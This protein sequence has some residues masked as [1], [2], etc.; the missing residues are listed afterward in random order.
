M[1][2]RPHLR[3]G[4][5]T[6]PGDRPDAPGPLASRRPELAR[7]NVPRHAQV[8]T[9]QQEEARIVV[10]PELGDLSD[11][12]LAKAGLPLA[13]AE[14]RIIRGENRTRA[15]CLPLRARRFHSSSLIAEEMTCSNVIARP[16]AK[17]AAKRSSFKSRR[18]HSRCCSYSAPSFG[19]R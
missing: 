19:G 13:V 11:N 7:R 17:A 10:I 3:E 18:A 15:R 6:R 8:Q 4:D 9:W 14:A 16:V 5:L 1:H 12:I 2:E